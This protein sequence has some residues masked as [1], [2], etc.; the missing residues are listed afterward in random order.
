MLA[1][2]K[3]LAHLRQRFPEVKTVVIAFSGG[4]DSHVLLHAAQQHAGLPVRALHVAH[5]LQE[6]SQHWPQHCERVCE[7]L[8]VALTVV[9]TEVCTQGEGT[10]AAA[11]K[12]RYAVF[13]QQL[14]ADELLLQGHHADDQAETLL[15]RLLRGT[16]LRGMGAMPESRPLGRAALW[17][18]LLSQGGDCIADYASAHGLRWVEDPSN[19]D[20]SFDR[21]YLRVAVAPALRQRWPLMAVQLSDA[22][23]RAREAEQLLNDLLQPV[24][25]RLC[26][27]D[28]SLSCGGLLTVPELQQRYILRAWLTNYTDLPPSEAQLGV[29]LRDVVRARRDGDPYLQLSG[30]QL[31]RHREH[32][33]WVEPELSDIPATQLWANTAQ[34][35]SV[36][37]AIL[38]MTSEFGQ[39]LSIPTDSVVE[40]RFRQGGERIRLRGGERPLKKLL[41]DLSVPS[42]LRSR[43]PLLYVGDEL[44]A[45]WNISIAEKYK[46]L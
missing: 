18:P 21:N 11:R 8:G 46:K 14:Q 28:G 3:A 44:A 17:R 32:L 13:E 38:S 39:K 6:E 5:G 26:A 10:E 15:L 42:W 2:G 29:A 9:E 31:R 19:A 30:A 1:V 24:L 23:R 33:Y 40:V 45:V 20:T 16:G 35:L 22:A 27:A 43:T 12:A 7:S 41:Q 25:A 34:P 37:S 4:R 36:A